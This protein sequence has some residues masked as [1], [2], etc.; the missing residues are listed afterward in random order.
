MHD[1]VETQQHGAVTVVTLNRSDVRN[2]VDADTAHRL[3]DAFV[4]F[5]ADPDSRVADS[6]AHRDTSVPA[7][8]CRPVPGWRSTC[9]KAPIHLLRWIF[10][11][12]M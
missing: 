10:R 6:M 3:Y 7:G 4:A 9:S 2:A 5:D 1:T 8:I 12:T 11:W